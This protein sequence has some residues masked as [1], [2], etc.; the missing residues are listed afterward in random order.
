MANFFGSCRYYVLGFKYDYD[1]RFAWNFY[2]QTN[3]RN[4][5]LGYNTTVTLPGSCALGAGVGPNPTAFGS[6]VSSN[7]KYAFSAPGPSNNL[8]VW[9]RSVIAPISSCVAGGGNSYPT[10][11]LMLTVILLG[12]NRI[13]NE[14]CNSKYP[15]SYT[16][17]GLLYYNA[18][19]NTLLE[20]EKMAGGRATNS[21]S[22]PFVFGPQTSLVQYQSL[23]TPNCNCALI[24]G[25]Q[26]RYGVYSSGPATVNGFLDAGSF[27]WWSMLYWDSYPKFMGLYMTSARIRSTEANIGNSVNFTYITNGCRQC[28]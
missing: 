16:N 14:R 4:D 21:S 17:V 7:L 22:S 6:I 2:G 8:T 19:S 28:I 20:V 23:F 25:C 13:G 24:N 18:D 3:T 15:F 1:T 12:M 5:A 11:Q 26:Q 10:N 9:P 27:G